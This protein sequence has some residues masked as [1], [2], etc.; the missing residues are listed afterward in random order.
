MSELST[1]EDLKAQAEF[2][3]LTGEAVAKFIFQQ[4]SFERDERARERAEREKERERQE[5]KEEREFELAKLKLA[6][7]TPNQRCQDSSIRGPELPTYQD[8]ED[9]AAYLTRFERIAELLQ[10]QKDTLAVRLGSLLTGKA[11]ELYSSLDTKTICD[12]S[13]LKQALLLGFDKTPERYRQ[14]FRSNK[15]RFGENY[16][17]FTTRLKQLFDSWFEASKTPR[18]FEALRE[19]IVLDQFLASLSPDLRLF[20]K[21][22]QISNLATAVEKADNW[23][24]ARN[25]YPIASPSNNPMGA[26]SHISNKSPS[27]RRKENPTPNPP[28]TRCFNCGDEGHLRNRCPMNPRAFKDEINS[29]F[30]V[31]FCMSDSSPSKYTVPGTINGS[32]STTFLRDTGCDGVVV[33][34][35]ALPD[36]DI[37]SCPKVLVEDYLGVVKEFPIVRCMLRCPY[38]E[39]WVNAIRAPIKRCSVLIGNIP[40][41]REPNDPLLR[42]EEFPSASQGM[43]TI[44]HPASHV[45]TT[46]LP[47]SDS[48]GRLRVNAVETRSSKMKRVHPLVLPPLQPLDITPEEFSLLQQSCPTLTG[49]RNKIKLREEEHTKD[50]STYG[51]LQCN[52][53][54]YRKC[55]SSK[56]QNKVG[57][58]TLV[59]PQECRALILSIG[60][61]NPLAGHFSHRKTGLKISENFFWPGMYAEIRD[62]CRSCDVCQRLSVKGR[63]RPVPLH[64]VPIVTEPFSKVAVDLVGPLSPPSA[65]GHRYILT[66]VDYATG[67]P[68]AVPLRQVDSTSVAEALLS[69]FSRVGI[70]REVLSD[71]GTQ[72][73]SQLMGELHNLLGVKPCF[74]TPF[75]PSANGRV[76]RLHAPL[77]ASLRKLCSEKPREWHRYVIP[78]L[79]ALREIPSDRTGFSAFELL[80]GRTVRGPLSVLRD[81]W[82]DRTLQDDDRSTFRY[83]VE[84]QDKLAETAKI[85]AENADISSSRYKTYFDVRSQDRQF[86]P[87]DE[88]LL[89]LPS[90]TSKL[91][92][93]WKGPFKILERRGKVDYLI[94]CPKGPRLYH[95]NLLKRYFRRTQVSFAHV[96][97]EVSFGEDETPVTPCITDPE[98]YS[99]NLPITPDGQVDDDTSRPQ[100]NPNLEPKDCN[101]LRDLLNEYQDTFS[102]TPGCTSTIEHDIVLNTTARI[103]CKIYPVPLYLKPFFEEEVNRLFQQGIIQRSS[104]QHCSP[105]VMVPKP[106]GSYRMAVDYRRL[107]AATVFHAEPGCNIEEDLHKF[108]GA[109]FFSELDLS[110]AYYQVPLSDKSK[111]LTAFPTHLG[112]MEFCRLPFGLV[113]ACATYIRLMRIVLSGLSNVTF[114]FDNIFIYS[115]DWTQHCSTLRAVL[116]RIRSHGLTLKLSKCHFGFP[117]IQ[118]LGF[119]LSGEQ[120]QP[121]P[122]KVEA[123]CRISPPKTKKI[124][125][126]FLGM[127]SFY[128]AFIPQAADLTAPLSD[129]LRKTV[130]EP[131]LWTKDMLERFN[132]LK[133]ILGATPV[134]RLPD[135]SSPFVL[136]TD[137]SSR[138]LG[139]VL[140]QYHQGLPHPVAY[141]S[142]KLLP[143][144]T[145]YST[146]EREC[147]AVI[148]GIQKFDYYLRGRE[149][150][151]EVDHKPLVYLQNFKGKNDRLLRW[152]LSLQAYRF[153]VVHVA[154]ADNLGADLLS[155]I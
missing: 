88:V 14:D 34:E 53:L 30:K 77:K 138:G 153:R 74:T 20:I 131:L 27:L 80:Y 127:V 139:A 104:S 106:D 61:D 120:L 109:K 29:K 40:G 22:Q 21:E 110:K 125:R 107:N 73:T 11:A 141:A 44:F 78:T 103:H 32:W 137:A 113:T 36:A 52:G 142:Q 89:L 81:L 132:Q 23:A 79:F 64:P 7:E 94:D 101:A 16:R 114:Y 54:L 75:H 145:K 123:I 15:I 95:A 4:Q 76:E 133:K 37:S 65:E 25:A 50:G 2:I 148:S 12:F 82:E 38:Y 147:L 35:E 99:C 90:D 149:F 60:H 47:S 24:S 112:L 91:L 41:A 58:L 129:L 102:D 83:V 13:L 140:L 6:N 92:V 93:A 3:G 108:A 49:I 111:S 151:L 150:I 87:G 122:D 118:Y 45:S 69:I 128:K 136:R 119:I 1:L 117:S 51:Y 48:P 126:S 154:G 68:E 56:H 134:L 71:Q 31:G 57:K 135:A 43:E 86:Q 152:A 62:F 130:R 143:R 8:G 18:T 26:P 59:V 144:Q 121:Q 70:P 5:R 97:D 116:E 72:F 10:V 96:L 146:I 39:G 42:R 85:A 33:S 155:R 67:F 105:V 66:L 28:R 100:I 115:T 55:L 46:L 124:L 98:D 17:Q 9:I 84:L 19:F 63:C